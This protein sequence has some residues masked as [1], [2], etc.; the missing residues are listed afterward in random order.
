MTKEEYDKAIQGAED[1]VRTEYSKKIKQLEEKI[2][3]SLNE[4]FK[5]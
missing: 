3:K 4:L 5:G 2:Q 1:R